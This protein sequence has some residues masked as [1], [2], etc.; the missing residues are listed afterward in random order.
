MNPIKKF[1]VRI[2]AIEHPE[3]SVMIPQVSDKLTFHSSENHI[4]VT[5]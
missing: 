5:T 2:G 3:R 1:H 4:S